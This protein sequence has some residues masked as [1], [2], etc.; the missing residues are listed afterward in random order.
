MK[1]NIDVSC[2]M[3]P[4]NSFTI[5]EKNNRVTMAML[6][7]TA[8]LD[9]KFSDYPKEYENKMKLNKLEKKLKKCISN[10]FGNIERNANRKYLEHI[11]NSVARDWHM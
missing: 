9:V 5:Q 1:I 6:L 8:Y 7:P 11:I 4:P 3:P 2:L 10:H